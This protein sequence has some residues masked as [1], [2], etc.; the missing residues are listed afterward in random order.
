M[1]WLLQVCGYEHWGA[2]IFSNYRFLLIHVQEWDCR[3]ALRTSGQTLCVRA[4]GRNR[5]TRTLTG[6]QRPVEMVPVHRQ[7]PKPFTFLSSCPQRP[8]AVLS[9]AI[10]RGCL[11]LPS[12]LGQ[13]AE[14]RWVSVDSSELGFIY[15][16][17]LWR[18]LP[19]RP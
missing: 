2:C 3:I 6:W 5:R 17:P 15:K 13:G 11:C 14:R 18:A 9:F 12:G 19:T 4:G 7:L 16:R 10:G 1:S 8:S